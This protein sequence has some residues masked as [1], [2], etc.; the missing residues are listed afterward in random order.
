[1]ELEAAVAPDAV[2]RSKNGFSIVKTTWLW[3]LGRENEIRICDGSFLQM[4]QAFLIEE[5][6]V[7]A[8]P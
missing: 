5:E 6:V 8:G 3:E 7:I 4:Q 2:L 1:M